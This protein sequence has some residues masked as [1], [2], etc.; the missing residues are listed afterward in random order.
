MRLFDCARE[1]NPSSLKPLPRRLIDPRHYSPQH[2]RES[3][4]IEV[5]RGLLFHADVYSAL[6]LPTGVAVRLPIWVAVRLTTGVAVRCHRRA[7]PSSAG[8]QRVVGR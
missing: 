2:C 5:I 6:R 3:S 7:R 8:R 4:K 1:G